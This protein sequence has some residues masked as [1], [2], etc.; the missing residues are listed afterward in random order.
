MKQIGIYEAKSKL[1]QLVDDA[2]RGEAVVITRHGRPVARLVPV[3]VPSASIAE[4]IE[5]IREF[6]K[7][8]RLDGL[9]IKELINEGRKH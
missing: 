2:A 8:R 7:G 9:S 1:S 5:A 3:D 6:R 4:T